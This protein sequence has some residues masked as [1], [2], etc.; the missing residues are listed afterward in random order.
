MAERGRLGLPGAP[1]ALNT[2]VPMNLFATW[3]VD[4]SS[5]SCVP[6]YAP[7]LRFVRAHLPAGQD[8]APP[9]A[10]GPQQ[11]EGRG[12]AAG[13]RRGDQ[14]SARTLTPAS[15]AGLRAAD[16]RHLGRS[17]SRLVLPL[18]SRVHGTVTPQRP[19]P[20][21]HS[22]VASPVPCG[23]GLLSL[24]LSALCR[25]LWREL[26]SPFYSLLGAC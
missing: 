18:S 7:A 4:G 20:E 13:L 26:R 11:G 22:T 6:R 9:S 23:S 25:E 15:R 17:S 3:E 12:G 14:C 2:P 8:P 16:R 24:H 1:G 19:G 5:P 21:A 10:R